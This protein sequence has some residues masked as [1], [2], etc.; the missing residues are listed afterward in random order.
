MGSTPFGRPSAGGAPAAGTPA[1]PIRSGT[2]LLHL[3]VIYAL[4]AVTMLT[5][6]T[7]IVTTMVNDLSVPK[8]TAGVLWSVVGGLSIFSGPLFGNVSDR[9][10][11]RAGIVSALVAQA[12]AYGLIAAGTGTIG[13][14]V[15][16]LLFGLSAWS[17]PSIVSAA[18]GDY[19]GPERAAGIFA[20]LTLI[21]A[22]GQVL[23]PAGAGFLADWTGGF[24]AAYGVT[25]GLNCV[26]AILCLFLRPPTSRVGADQ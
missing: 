5:Y 15:S 3:G 24:A 16:I 14:Y 26:A 10:G 6:T 12:I 8:A 17:L 4:F 18:A 7:F 11:H 22:V 23:G 13:L 21:F 1:K 20:L 19:F 9:W 25:T 2:F